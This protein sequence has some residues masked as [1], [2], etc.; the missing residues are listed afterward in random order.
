M[1]LGAALYHHNEI[2]TCYDWIENQI[3]TTVIFSIE[4]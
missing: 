4:I 2:S 1:R 3:D